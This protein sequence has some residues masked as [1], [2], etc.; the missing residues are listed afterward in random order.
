MCVNKNLHD[1]VFNTPLQLPWAFAGCVVY[2]QR[3]SGR[4]LLGVTGESRARVQIPSL[5]QEKFG[6]AL[7]LTFQDIFET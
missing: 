2:L 5:L 6:R 3:Q 4:H 7:L 1:C